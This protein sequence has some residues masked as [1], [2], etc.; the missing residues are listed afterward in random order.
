MEEQK[1]DIDELTKSQYYRPF[2][3]FAPSS[4]NKI[5]MEHAL[6]RAWLN[7]DFEIDK[8]WSRATYFWAFIAAAFAGY[9]AV[10]SSTIHE[11]FKSQF[12]FIVICM[13]FVFSIAWLFVNLGSKKWQENWEKH[14]DMLEDHVT[15]PLYKTVLNRPGYS[16]SKININ[17]SRFICFVWFFLGFIQGFDI[18]YRPFVGVVYFE[19]DIII[20]ISAIL[21]IAFSVFLYCSCRNDAY[22]DMNNNGSFSFNRRMKNYFNP[23]G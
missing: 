12:A 17:I 11:P 19:I 22:T 14:I 20:L 18:S 4:E 16:V 1:Q 3:E 8:Y 9:I 7:R 5:K 10:I 6:E 21:T 15:G 13:G 23:L 2:L